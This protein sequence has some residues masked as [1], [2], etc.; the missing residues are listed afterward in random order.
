MC[1]FV[2][3]TTGRNTTAVTEL[4]P[5]RAP[6]AV[7]PWRDVGEQRDTDEKTP[8]RHRINGGLLALDVLMIALVVL[9][10]GLM[11]FLFLW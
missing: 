8:R 11:L 10:A 4:D 9:A 1:A 5:R 7:M 6:D 3:T 2:P